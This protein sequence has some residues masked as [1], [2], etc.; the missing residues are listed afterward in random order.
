MTYL[1]DLMRAGK[2][3]K[4]GALA[5]KIGKIIT[6]YNSSRLSHIDP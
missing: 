6:R 5:D 4:A 2:V 1:D 3:D